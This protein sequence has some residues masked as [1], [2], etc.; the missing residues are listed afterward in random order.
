VP[1]EAAQYGV[2]TLATRLGSL[3]EVLPGDIPVLDGFDISAAVSRAW[4]LLHNPSVA[5]DLTRALEQRSRSFTW[6]ATAEK[7][8]GLFDAALGQPRGRIR[9]IE[10]EG[11]T[12]VGVL[13]AACSS[14]RHGSKWN[15]R[16]CSRRSSV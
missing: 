5:A 7:L 8:I 6:D 9:A 3:D 13:T 10:R 16:R 15:S 2:P 12:L 1:F 14:A 4:T 11:G